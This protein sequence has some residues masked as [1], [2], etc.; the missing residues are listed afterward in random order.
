MR[1]LLAVL[2]LVLLTGCLSATRDRD[3]PATMGGPVEDE[4]GS[5][6]PPTHSTSSPTSQNSPPDEMGLK[7]SLSASGQ[8]GDWI[9]IVQ[10]FEGK[11]TGFEMRY[12][13]K[14]QTSDGAN[15]LRLDYVVNHAGNWGLSD[16]FDN[17]LSASDGEFS[18]RGTLAGSGQDYRGIA[19]AWAADQAWTLDVEFNTTAKVQDLV[20]LRG[21]G[22]AFGV[23]TAPAGAVPG[24]FEVS[25]E[26]PVGPRE[27]VIAEPDVGEPLTPVYT[28]GP[29]VRA[30]WNPELPDGRTCA[31]LL[32]LTAFQDFPAAGAWRQEGTL[33]STL[34]TTGWIEAPAIRY[35]TI[36]LGDA[37]LPDGW[38]LASYCNSRG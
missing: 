30:E 19:S 27:W 12:Q 38:S 2:V 17:V 29:A 28:N 22:T 25:V 10:R 5:V 18:T 4:P 35:A 13:T 11:V 31:P 36:P 7:D 9:V 21:N 16:Q 24:Q 3:D 23:A 32:D 1:Q 34:R 26:L 37:D 6:A 33:R 14:F 15:V 8:A 20:V